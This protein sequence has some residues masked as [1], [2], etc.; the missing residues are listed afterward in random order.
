MP[1][2]DKRNKQRLAEDP[3]LDQTVKLYRHII[4]TILLAAMSVACQAAP[5]ATEVTVLPE[6]LPATATLVPP[7]V[8]PMPLEFDGDSAYAFLEAQMALGPR[9]PGSPGHLELRDY[10]RSTL[11]DM[12][13]SLETEE[14][15]YR[16]FAAMNIV[17]KANQGVGDIIILGAHYDTRRV[18]DQTEGGRGRGAACTWGCRWRQWRGRTIGTGP[19]LR[20][21]GGAPGDMAG[22]F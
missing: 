14:F 22:L 4:F 9:W 7:T 2:S 8:A 17:A 15:D 18:A 19:Y 10:I 11:T 6:V 16:G 3:V 5:Q 20:F 1:E 12:G 21:R 13:W